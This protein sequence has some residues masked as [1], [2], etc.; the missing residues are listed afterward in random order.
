[1]IF[2]AGG[3]VVKRIVVLRSLYFQLRDLALLFVFATWSL[4]FLRSQCNHDLFVLFYAHDQVDT[5]NETMRMR[6]GWKVWLL[7]NQATGKQGVPRYIKVDPSSLPVE[8][9]A[10]ADSKECDS[11][12]DQV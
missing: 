3:K 11:V 9:E 8:P 6:E 1:M 12:P 7:P 5:E 2:L 10:G 4:H